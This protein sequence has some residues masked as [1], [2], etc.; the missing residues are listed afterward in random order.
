MFYIPHG[1]GPLSTRGGRSTSGGSAKQRW[2][3]DDGAYLEIEHKSGNLLRETQEVNGGIEQGRLEFLFEVNLAPV[4]E[5]FG[6]L[7]DVDQKDDVD[8]E[9]EEDRE[10]DV[11]IEDIA[12]GS[13]L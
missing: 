7:G 9:L 10:E 3:T 11:E 1:K 8:G 6:Q 5:G 4:L 13:L 12:E 2:Q